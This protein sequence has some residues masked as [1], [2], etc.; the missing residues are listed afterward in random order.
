MDYTSVIEACSVEQDSGEVAKHLS[1]GW[2]TKVSRTATKLERQ[3]LM[4]LLAAGGLATTD[5]KDVMKYSPVVGGAT[6]V[7]DETSSGWLGWC[8]QLC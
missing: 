5:A 4:T 1:S 8:V 3:L 2:S 6:V 7:D